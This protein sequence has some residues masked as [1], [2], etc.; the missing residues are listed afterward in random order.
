MSQWPNPS[1]DPDTRGW[2]PIFSI[3]LAI[4][5]TVVVCLRLGSIRKASQPLGLD[6]YLACVSWVF[7]LLFTATCIAGT[8]KYG[9]NRHIWDVPASMHSPAALVEWLSVFFYFCCTGVTK[10]SVLYFHRRLDPPCTK[11]FERIMRAFIVVTGA[12]TLAF[13][14]AQSLLCHPTSDYWRV[15][16]PAAAAVGHRSCG[17]QHVFYPFQGSFSSF[18]T[19]YS[20][21][22]PVL[23]MRNLPMSKI[24]RY[25]LRVATILGLIVLAAGIARTVFLARLVNSSN[26]DATWNAF[27]VF[28][29]SDLECQLSLICASGPFLQRY[30]S[31]YPNVPIV[32]IDPE[33]KSRS[34][35]VVSRVGSSFSGQL[36]RSLPFRRSHSPRQVDISRPQAVEI[37][38]WE[39]ET[40]QSA[41]L[42]NSPLDVE[43]YERYLAGH[44]GPAPPP[45]DSRELFDQYRREHGEIL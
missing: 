10:I 43:T 37:P 20:I 8:M 33:S 4:T 39:F 42:S 12:S 3:L 32:Y 27:M 15:P 25:G 23:V 17:S 31:E 7:A 44:Y 2:F 13:I 38:E 40:L 36:R 9:F 35:S 29:W 19:A 34:H 21:M 26:G 24:Q 22:L 5:S 30:L 28:V 11:M 18:S 41:R 16:N 1:I 6:D 45:K 14:L